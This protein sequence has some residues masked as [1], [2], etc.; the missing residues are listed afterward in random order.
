MERMNG[1]QEVGPSFRPTLQWHHLVGITFFA[2]CGGDYGIEETV[3]AGGAR[4]ALLG[5]L[6]LPWFYCLPT[7]LMAAEL[8]SMIP[9]A[10]GYIVWIDR[11]FG[12]RAAH[13]NAIWNLVSNAFDNAIYPVMFADYLGFFPAMHLTGHK[14]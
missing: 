13:L 7:A 4:L 11:A 9:E 1:V 5:L 12:R 10:G 14:S 2:V 3:G 8:S 6:V